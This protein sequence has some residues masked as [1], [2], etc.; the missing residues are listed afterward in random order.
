MFRHVTAVKDNGNGSG[1]HHY[2]LRYKPSGGIMNSIQGMRLN[3]VWSDVPTVDQA[4]L[5][6]CCKEKKI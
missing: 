3:D 5:T 2:S 4:N 6:G 1:G